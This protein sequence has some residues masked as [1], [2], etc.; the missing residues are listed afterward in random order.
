MGL[1]NPNLPSG[2]ERSTSS[3]TPA[4]TSNPSSSPSLGFNSSSGMTKQALLTPDDKL[5]IE[6]VYKN[7]D[8]LKMWRLSSGTIVEK[9]MERFALTC[10]F[11]Q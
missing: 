9:E 1:Y 11:E 5:A 10:I 7:L 2:V 6:E 3:Y 8:T 4:S